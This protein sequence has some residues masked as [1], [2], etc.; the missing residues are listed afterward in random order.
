MK[1]FLYRH[2][3]KQDDAYFDEKVT[4]FTQATDNDYF[5]NRSSMKLEFNN[6]LSLSDLSDG[7]YQ[8]LFI[9]A[10]LDLFD[11]E[12][13]LFLLDEVDSHL[14]YKNIENL[15]ECFTFY[16]RPSNYY[17]SFIRLYYLS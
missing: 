1:I 10:L 5:F 7:E 12:D 9:Y 16:S 8:I 6:S 3:K 15:V 14:H 2:L 17:N 13:T 4:F 11:S